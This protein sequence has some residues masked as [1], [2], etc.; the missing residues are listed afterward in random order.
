MI[1]LD[2]CRLNCLYKRQISLLTPTMDPSEELLPPTVPAIFDIW[3]LT[4]IIYRQA[5]AGLLALS[6]LY[7][8][9]AL[10][11]LRKYFKNYSTWELC[12]PLQ[13][14][15]AMRSF[16]PLMRPHVS[17]SH[18]IATNLLWI[19]A[20]DIA[21]LVFWFC[22]QCLHSLI[23]LRFTALHYLLNR[24]NSHADFWFSSLNR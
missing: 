11:S 13:A 3:N 15:I 19:K 14:S 2:L 4:C 6:R 23:V 12:S 5:V 21:R 16:S 24:P 1:N 17:L 20:A 22:I 8:S 9:L 18:T 7:G 10:K